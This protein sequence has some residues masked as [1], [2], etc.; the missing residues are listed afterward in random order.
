MAPDDDRP[1]PKVK[2]LIADKSLSEVVDEATRRELERWFGLPS[3]QELAE[4][5]PPPEQ[6]PDRIAARERS[7][8]AAAQVDPK[9]L[10]SIRSRT[11]DN[12]ESL[13]KFAPKLE[14]RADPTITRFDYAMADRLHSIAEP[15]EIERPA[16]LEDELK[17][18]APKALL[19]DLHRPETD[20]QKMFE[21]VDNLP[22]V[23]AVAEVNRAMKTSWKLP[24][25]GVSPYL[26]A[27]ELLRE[28][29][30]ERQLPWTML[31]TRFERIHR[32][33]QE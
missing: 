24:A 9:L 11:L 4:Q 3:F 23:D 20:F 26:T 16:D 33:V 6:D 17:E 1:D 29:R 18:C 27:Q 32:R 14:V 28:L 7:D 25:L 8:R 5:P 19:R 12:P 30:A 10:A 21:P 2:D 22:R 13:I 31:V 15:R